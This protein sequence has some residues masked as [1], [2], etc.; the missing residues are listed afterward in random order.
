MSQTTPTP[1]RVATLIGPLADEDVRAAAPSLPFGEA[2]RGTQE[3]H[4]DP[5]SRSNMLV[6]GPARSGRSNAGDVIAAAARIQD[7][8]VIGI[9]AQGARDARFPVF[10]NGLED[11]EQVILHL[12]QEMRRRLAILKDRNL[13]SVEALPEKQ[14][15]RR[16]FLLVDGMSKLPL[17]SGIKDE[18]LTEARA[19]YYQYLKRV[20]D[21]MT[22][23]GTLVRIHVIVVTDKPVPALPWNTSVLTLRTAGRGTFNDGKN[24]PISGMV[25]AAPSDAQLTYAITGIPA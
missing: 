25:W 20:V 7:A 2:T 19:E 22:R 17:Q 12:Y 18:D 16:M 21:L 10:A 1:R 8:N 6:S 23:V 4:Y 9:R 11:A 3:L 14:R 15:P 5:V 24:P 13:R